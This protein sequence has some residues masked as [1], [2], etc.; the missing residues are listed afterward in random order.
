MPNRCDPCFQGLGGPPGSHLKKIGSQDPWAGEE[1][2]LHLSKQALLDPLTLS[3]IYKPLGE[4]KAF[5]QRGN[6]AP[7]GHHLDGFTV[8]REEK[9]GTSG[10]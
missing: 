10:K 4:V 1:D 6:P 9:R 2:G 7:P 5:P 3:Q 8:S